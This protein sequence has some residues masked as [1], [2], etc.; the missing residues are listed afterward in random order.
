MTRKNKK[1]NQNKPVKIKPPP[2][3]SGPP[4]YSQFD[5]INQKP[6]EPPPYTSLD[7][8][9]PRNTEPDFNGVLKKKL[10]QSFQM[11]GKSGAD[12]P[13]GTPRTGHE[14]LE[15][16]SY[17]VPEENFED[18][19]VH[20]KE[21][22]EL[23]EE[24]DED[25]LANLFKKAVSCAVGFGSTSPIKTREFILY[26]SY[27]ACPQKEF[28]QETH[29]DLHRIYRC[30]LERNVNEELRK[31]MEYVDTL[32][33]KDEIEKS[34]STKKSLL[35]F[36]AKN[37]SHY[38]KRE[39]FK[40]CL[41]F[42]DLIGI[43]VRTH[44]A[45]IN[46]LE[47]SFTL[48]GLPRN[49]ELP[50]IDHGLDQTRQNRDV[51]MHHMSHAQRIILTKLAEK[52]PNFLGSAVME[53]VKYDENVRK[54]NELKVIREEEIATKPRMKMSVESILNA[55]VKYRRFDRPTSA[56]QIDMLRE[57]LERRNEL[58]PDETIENTNELLGD[59]QEALKARE[60]LAASLP[61]LGIAPLT[62][63]R[64]MKELKD[65]SIE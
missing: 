50:Q 41:L 2:S 9:I 35:E 28:I 5:F 14:I 63:E 8:A 55:E 22:R 21:L 62:V 51:Q 64:M 3:S 38:L 33:N 49:H 31:C 43:T 46:E 59:S 39:L 34:C 26:C 20:K 27:G 1:K 17:P 45:L 4:G 57:I 58:A 6:S 11:W 32:E 56:T 48:D 36:C 23:F 12:E 13:V 65:L 61:S 29:E 25:K 19:I 40:S 30:V 47:D 7:Y 52:M 37:P 44:M 10:R 24:Q 54:W 60:E 16:L 18:F 42:C 15:M 53:Y